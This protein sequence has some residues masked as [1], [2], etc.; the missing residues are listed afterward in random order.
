MIHDSP[1]GPGCSSQRSQADRRRLPRRLCG[2][3]ARRGT[4][5]G[6][7]PGRRCGALGCT[8]L[9]SAAPGGSRVS[10]AL[11]PPRADV[12]RSLLCFAWRCKRGA[13]LGT[14]PEKHW[15]TTPKT[16]GCSV[17][18]HRVCSFYFP[19]PYT[20]NTKKKKIF[21]FFYFWGKLCLPVSFLLYL[22]RA[23]PSF[24]SVPWRSDNLFCRL[25]MLLV[26]KGFGAR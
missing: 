16:R 18:N 8:R 7:Q 9:G 12:G 11:P 10:P 2:D 14:H 1:E 3:L 20:T 6:H 22:R 17:P 26:A 15:R 19:P 13:S 25:E 4:A 21:L 5:T 24:W 23:P